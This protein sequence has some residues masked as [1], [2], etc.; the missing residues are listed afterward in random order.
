MGRNWPCEFRATVF[1]TNCGRCGHLRRQE[2]KQGCNHAMPSHPCFI[3]VNRC[4]LTPHIGIVEPGL[5]LSMIEILFNSHE[6]INGNQEKCKF[7]NFIGVRS[8]CKFTGFAGSRM[9]F[10]ACE[11]LADSL[12]WEPQNPGSA[13][14]HSR[15][16]LCISTPNCFKSW[17]SLLSWFQNP[18]N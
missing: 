7:S 13:W 9:M 4:F 3:D 5:W 14:W 8:H 2:A 15:E 11:F 18:P 10:L 1:R 16:H 6:T 17:A 12:R